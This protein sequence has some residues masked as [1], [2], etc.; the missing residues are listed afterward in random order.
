M[1]TRT[2]T[3]MFNSASINSKNLN[4][5]TTTRCSKDSKKGL[6]RS[7]RSTPNT[8]EPGHS[9]STGHE[10]LHRSRKSIP[11]IPSEDLHV[12]TVKHR[13]TSEKPKGSSDKKSTEVSE[14][15]TRHQTGTGQQL[16]PDAKTIENKK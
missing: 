8:T 6:H 3:V 7:K 1:T 11:D 4:G 9:N 2:D 16:K 14:N 10:V 5:W 12:K 15:S 13:G